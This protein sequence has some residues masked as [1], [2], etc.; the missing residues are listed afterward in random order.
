MPLVFEIVLS[1][2]VISLIESIGGA[3]WEGGGAGEEP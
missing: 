3:E 1:T 2:A